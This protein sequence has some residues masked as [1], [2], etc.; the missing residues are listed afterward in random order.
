MLFQTFAF[1]ATQ[2][3]VKPL[4][5]RLKSW[6]TTTRSSGNVAVENGKKQLSNLNATIEPIDA[7]RTLSAETKRVQ[8]GRVE[9]APR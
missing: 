8:T 7:S 4:I 6:P 9:P 1:D 3:I 2:R 5:A